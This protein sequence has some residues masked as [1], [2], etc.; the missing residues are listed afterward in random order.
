MLLSEE[1]RRKI[2]NKKAEMKNHRDKG[3]IEKAH[4]MIAEIENLNKELEIQ[5]KIEEDEKNSVVNNSS[6]AVV[7]DKVD[8]NRAFNKALMNKSMTDAEKKYVADN[9]VENKAGATGVI[10]ADDVRGG[11][12]L[13]ATH[14]TQ[15]KELRRKRRALK[16]LVNVKSVTTRTGKF[17]TEGENALELLNFEELNT[18]TAKDL[19]FAQKSWAVKDYGLLIPVANQFIEDTDVNIV[20]YIGKEFVKASVRT[21]N[22][23]IITEFKK[24]EAKTI[25]GV[26]GLLEAL[27]VDLDPAIAENAKIITNQTSFNYLDTLEDKQGRKLLQPCLADPT[28]M[29]LR[30]KIIEVFADEELTPKTSNNLTFYVGDAEEYLNFYEKKG[31]EVATSAEAGFKE[32]ATWLRVVERFDVGVVDD[33]ALVL[34]EMAKPSEA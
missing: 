27:N 29:M 34:C 25:K 22:K 26:N 33:E 24:L 7:S 32:Y 21:E 31:I 6:T 30:N 12:L 4:A 16:E 28:K 11:Y 13:P 3:E 9:L 19:K 10:G 20:D 17:N 1:I 14:E 8:E 15:I 23:A 2:E 5:L 18:L